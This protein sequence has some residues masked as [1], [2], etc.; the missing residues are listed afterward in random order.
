MPIEPARDFGHGN[1]DVPEGE[2][3]SDLRVTA[4]CVRALGYGLR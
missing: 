1:M 2:F 4:A 3:R